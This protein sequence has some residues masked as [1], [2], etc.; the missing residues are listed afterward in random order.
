MENKTLT[1]IYLICKGW[2]NK[3]LYKNELEAMNSYY[4][5]HYGCDDITVDV[6]FALHLFLYPLTLEIIKRDPDKAKFLFMDV[7]FGENNQLFVNV[8][9]RRII[10]MIIQCTIGIFNLSEYE[11]MFDAA[12]DLI[13]GATYLTKDNENWIYMGKFDVYDRYENWKNKGKHF[14]FWKGSYFEHYRSMPK[15]KFIKCID[16]KCNEKYADIFDKLEGESEYSPY[17]SSKDEYKYFTLDEFKKDDYWGSI[18]FISEYYSGNKYVF[19]T[20]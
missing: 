3:S 16:D 19:E 12:K 10:H 13:I 9:Y 6:P 11:E 2:Y 8:M 17:D 15:N 20:L 5:K 1:D 14:W 4:H 7:T 18:R